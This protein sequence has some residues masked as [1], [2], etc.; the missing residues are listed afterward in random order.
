MK[1]YCIQC[2]KMLEG[3][4][5]TKFCSHSCSSIYNNKQRKLTTK[6]KQKLVKCSICEQEFWASIH[7]STG[8]CRCDKC[9]MQVRPHFH[10]N[11]KTFYQLSSQT[12]KIV[13]KRMNVGC[14][15]CGWNKAACDI[16][17]I[18]PKKF[19]GDNSDD[20]LINLCPNC[21]REAHSGL[22]SNDVL[23]ENNF[24]NKK[25]NWKDFYHPS[26]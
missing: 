20:N 3:K 21:H 23:I 15:I 12:R 8:K 14:S 2:G 7:I 13:M 25:I 17:H 24:T 10:I 1:G 19:G 6:G 22:I 5:Q 18:I 11:P 9:K 26:N 4:W 16:H